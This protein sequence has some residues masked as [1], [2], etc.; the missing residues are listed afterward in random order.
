MRLQLFFK[1]SK[2]TFKFL[3]VS[4]KFSFSFSRLR[5]WVWDGSSSD[6]DDTSFGGHADADFNNFQGSSRTSLPV[7]PAGG[8]TELEL[9]VSQKKSGVGAWNKFDPN[10]SGSE[11]LVLSESNQLFE[12]LPEVF[13]LVV[14]FGGVKMIDYLKEMDNLL[15]KGSFPGNFFC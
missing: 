9:A 1:L 8:L 2:S 3:L 4:S 12:R 13:G 6:D 11:S 7:V 15:L 14:R 5:H 10:L